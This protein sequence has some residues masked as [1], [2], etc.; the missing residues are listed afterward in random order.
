MLFDSMR[1]FFFAIFCTRYLCF[2]RNPKNSKVRLES[3]CVTFTECTLCCWENNLGGKY[4]ALAKDSLHK[5]FVSLV[6]SVNYETVASEPGGAEEIMRVSCSYG[7][8]L[9]NILPLKSILHWFSNSPIK[10]YL[11]LV[12]PCGYLYYFSYSELK[13]MLFTLL[14]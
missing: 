1:L 2:T 11:V 13:D 9:C 10:R 14:P 6:F 3:A 12:K 8:F 5:I 4:S 7:D